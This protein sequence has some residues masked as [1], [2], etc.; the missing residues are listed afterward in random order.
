VVYRATHLPLRRS[1]AL[2]LT[3]PELSDD[4]L[5]RRRF[6][7]ESEIAASLRH[8]NVVTVFDA[9]EAEGSLYV[10][11]E[12]I[13]GSDLRGLIGREGRLEPPRLSVIVTQIASALDAAHAGGWCT[14]TSSRATSSSTAGATG[15]SM[16]TSPT[17]V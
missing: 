2:K 13:E 15:T 6:E 11:M 10:T 7:R 1:V 9:G 12:L 16:R 4:P 14:A 8:P 17:S 3:A 5:F